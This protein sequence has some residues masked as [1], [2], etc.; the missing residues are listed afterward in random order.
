MTSR[1]R[2]RSSL[3]G[4]DF[5]NMTKSELESAFLQMLNNGIHGISFSVYLNDQKPG[6]LISAEQIADRM[7]I[8]KPYVKWIRSFSCTD[9]NEQIP[10]IAKENGIKTLVGAWLGDDPEKNE[11][12]IEGVIKVAKAGYADIVAVG[13]EVL[14]RGDL[15]EDEIINFINRVKQEIPGIPVGYVDAYYEFAVHPRVSDACDVILANCYPFW[16]GFPLEHSLA[17]LKNMYQVAMNAGKGKKVIITETGWP[18]LGSPER[19]AVP[20]YENAIRYFINAYTWADEADVEIFY[21]SSF[22]ELWKVGAE[23]DVGAYWGLWDINGN[24]KYR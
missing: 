5:S 17:Y 4:L 7:Q 24:L 10:K 12:E 20:S 11:K 21:F 22:D 13:N 6:S 2:F 15:T 19:A 3:A 1:G 16:E 9:G 8:V 23:G 18:N 14:L